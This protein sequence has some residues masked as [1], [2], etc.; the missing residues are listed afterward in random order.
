MRASGTALPEPEPVTGDIDTKGCEMAISRLA[1]VLLER[2]VPRTVAAALPACGSIIGQ[3]CN[4]SGAC[5]QCYITYANPP[6]CN[7]GKAKYCRWY[8][9]GPG[10]KNCTT[11]SF[12]GCL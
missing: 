3:K 11:W 9:P 6:I 10:V 2:L 1:D 7:G 8:I 4:S 5:Y 12:N